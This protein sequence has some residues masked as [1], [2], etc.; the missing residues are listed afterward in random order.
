MQIEILQHVAF[1]GPGAILNWAENQQHATNIQH[2]YQTP[3]TTNI[4]ATDAL[5]ILGG[6]MGANDGSQYSWMNQEKRLVE[7]ALKQNIPVLGICLGAQLIADVL[8]AKISRNREREIGWYPI[9]STSQSS[10]LAL[11]PTL[12]P[13]HW[14]GDTFETPINTQNIYKSDGCDNQAFLGEN[15]LGLQFHLEITSETVLPLIAA[16]SADFQAPRSSYVQQPEEILQNNNRFTQANSMMHELLSMF[17]H[18]ST[19][20]Q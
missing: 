18:R 17:F 7:T 2:V 1:E 3:I 14:H 15:L 4:A 20:A 16:S 5:I 13:L 8:G 19:C 11:P 9:V 10:K 12:T 6:P